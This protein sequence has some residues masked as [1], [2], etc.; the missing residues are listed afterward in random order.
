MSRFW[1]GWEEH[2]KDYRPLHDPPNEAILGWWCSGESG[3]LKT[4]FHTLCALVEAESEEAAK[5][6]VMEDWP[7][8]EH[9]LPP[10]WRFCNLVADDYM[11]G[12][13]FPVKAGSWSWRRI[14]GAK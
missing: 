7:P 4:S 12:P 10:S 13:R 6:A 14:T 9:R 2:S 8:P 1:L 3:D 5:I 11:P